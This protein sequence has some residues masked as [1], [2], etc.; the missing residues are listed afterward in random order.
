MARFSDDDVVSWLRQIPP[1]HSSPSRNPSC[2]RSSRHKRRRLEG[3]P[4]PPPSISPSGSGQ[5]PLFTITPPL[6]ATQ[7]ASR[8]PYSAMSTPT[9]KRKRKAL[10]TARSATAGDDEVD[11]LQTP[12]PFRMHPP[13]LPPSESESSNSEA[14][15]ASGNSSPTNE[16]S[17][18]ELG[19]SRITTRVLDAR[20]QGI[21]K[22]LVALLSDVNK[23]TMHR[24]Y[25]PQ[26]LEPALSSLDDD[27]P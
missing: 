11:D 2:Q 8:S 20:A 24:G 16:L 27:N 19:Q 7:P 12:R 10:P 18:L 25:I 23:I 5:N 15:S 4:S 9:P 21:P 22:E 6:H 1:Q 14:T 17:K 26:Y 3:P 13:S